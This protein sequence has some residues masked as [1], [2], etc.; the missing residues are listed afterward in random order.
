MHTGWF[1]ATSPE[2]L[3]NLWWRSVYQRPHA[4]R[5]GGLRL[6]CYRI[7]PSAPRPDYRSHRDEPNSRADTAAGAARRAKA[8]LHRNPAQ[9]VALA[10]QALAISPKSHEAHFIIAHA[11]MQQPG[12]V[13][14]PVL[15]RSA[16]H[17]RQQVKRIQ[18]AIKRFTTLFC[19]PDDL[20]D[21][22]TL[23]ADVDLWEAELKV[24]ADLHEWCE[25]MLDDDF[26]VNALT[27]H[28]DAHHRAAIET[29][30]ASS[31]HAARA[32][33]GLPAL[34]T[35][36]EIQRLFFRLAVEYGLD[37]DEADPSTHGK[38]RDALVALLKAF[39]RIP[40]LR[41]FLTT[42]STASPLN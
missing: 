5:A 24:F 1:D 29:L 15:F 28:D 19:R 32:D 33:D 7:A 38:F 2:K 23:P 20:D 41:E 12:L 36:D 25:E 16:A 13:P 10:R 3:Y 11:A 14:L 37:V 35:H 21:P 4:A 42:A 39:P 9:A 27:A 6:H 18:R 22:T 8:T 31:W 30:H 26:G 40:T 17:L 34:C